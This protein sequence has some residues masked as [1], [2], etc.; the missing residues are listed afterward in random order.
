MSECPTFPQACQGYL[1]SQTSKLMP[2]SMTQQLPDLWGSRWGSWS[3]PTGLGLLPPEK[4]PREA[5]VA[6]RLCQKLWSERG[7]EVSK[8][9]PGTVDGK[10]DSRP[11]LWPVL[12]EEGGEVGGRG[13]REG[14]EIYFCETEGRLYCCYFW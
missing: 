14:G 5:T 4:F 6:L 9:L 12:I 3:Q 1:L 7:R 2:L 10:I 13:G 8:I 11:W